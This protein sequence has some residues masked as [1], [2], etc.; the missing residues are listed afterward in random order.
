M[1]PAI[2]A[3]AH[4]NED[5]ASGQAHEQLGDAY[6]R[7]HDEEFE[8]AEHRA[9]HRALRDIHEGYQGERDGYQ[10]YNTSRYSAPRYYTSH[11]TTVRDFGATNTAGNSGPCIGLVD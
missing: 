8:K 2:P 3:L 5:D 10:G 9:Y 6:E 4:D 7:A 1:A 11:I